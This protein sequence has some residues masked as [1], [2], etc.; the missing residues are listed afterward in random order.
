VAIAEGNALGKGPVVFEL[1]SS[2]IALIRGRA[3]LGDPVFMQLEVWSTFLHIVPKASNGCIECAHAQA[4]GGWRP[5]LHAAG[6]TL[7]SIG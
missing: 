3:A 7:S 5:R 4:P 6:G 1:P 2:G